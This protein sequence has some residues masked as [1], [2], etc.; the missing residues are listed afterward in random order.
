[1]RLRDGARPVQKVD[2]DL[3]VGLLTDIDSFVRTCQTPMLVMPDNTPAPPYAVAMEIA[4]LAPQV[5]VTGYPWADF[6]REYGIAPGGN[7]LKEG[8]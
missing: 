8:P 6:T 1:L 4:A 2:R 7:H 3:L 5:E